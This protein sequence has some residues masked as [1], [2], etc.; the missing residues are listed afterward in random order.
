MKLQL[1]LEI[2]RCPFEK[3][4]LRLTFSFL[5]KFLRNVVSAINMWLQF[6]PVMEKELLG[7]TSDK[8]SMNLGQ[9]IEA[10]LSMTICE[11]DP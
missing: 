2:K 1:Y 7:L 8:F 3:S 4:P 6:D 10:F 5:S 11:S 9:N